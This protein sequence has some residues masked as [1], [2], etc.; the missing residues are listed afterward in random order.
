MARNGWKRLEWLELAENG[1]K[2]LK[3]AGI[4]RKW[5]EIADMGEN[6]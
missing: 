4:F 1:W 2:W 6:C 3:F 5:L